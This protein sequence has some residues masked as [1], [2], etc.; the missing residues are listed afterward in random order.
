MGV[1]A[2]ADPFPAGPAAALENLEHVVDQAVVWLGWETLHADPSRPFFH[3]HNDLVS[4]WGGPNADNVYRHARIDP[5]RRYRVRGRMHSCDE[6]LLAVRAGF[7]HRPVWGTKF[8][9]TASEHGIG[10]GDEF[11]LLFGPGDQAA[12]DPE[13]H[14]LPET[15]VMISV[16]EYYY[17]WQAEEPALFTIECLDPDPPVPVTPERFAERLD[18]SLNEVEESLSYWNQYLLDNR[19]DRQPN[20]FSANTVKVGKGLSNA[21]YE[22]CFWDLEPDQTLIIEAS[23]PDA[24]YWAVQL[25]MMG[26]FELVDPY[27]AVTSRN[28]VQTTVSPDGRVRFTVG[29]T[30]TGVANHL[31]TTGRREGLCTFRWFWPTSDAE[32]GIGASVVPTAEVWSH[33]PADTPRVDPEQRAEELAGRQ[34]HLRWRFRA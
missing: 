20:S 26:T 19:A 12:D 31:D 24:R 4:Q 14:P 11:D 34:A 30:D 22:F 21:R 23:V 25:Y 29:A 27:G 16:R 33:L 28:Q 2:M 18:E 1:A 32:P 5:A 15:T 9:L 10:P 17:D 3:R 6:F 13:M 8:Q 7:M